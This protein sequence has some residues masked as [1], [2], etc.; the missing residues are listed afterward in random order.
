MIVYGTDSG[1]RRWVLLYLF[2]IAVVISPGVTWLVKV[3]LAQT[4]MTLPPIIESPSILFIYGTLAV[5]FEHF[6]WRLPLLRKLGVVKLPNLNGT[7]TGALRSKYD[8][9][10]VEYP[11]TVTIQQEWLRIRVVFRTAQSS[12]HSTMAGV[13]VD[14]P[15]GMVL[16]YEY[17]SE[18]R[19]DA[20]EAMMMHRGTTRLVI[21]EEGGAITLDGGYYTSQ[22]RMNYGTITLQ[23][24]PRPMHSGPELVAPT[25]IGVD[26]SRSA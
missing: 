14:D 17:L 8:E 16:S 3:G 7:W 19:P 12:S 15:Q 1:E 18:P 23:R 20:D 6:L 11:V 24:G 9:F 22:P 5:A 26:A 25:P 10:A 4:G 2:V 13:F 21:N